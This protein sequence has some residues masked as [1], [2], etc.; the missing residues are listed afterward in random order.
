MS[1]PPIDEADQLEREVMRSEVEGLELLA[2]RL[3][4]QDRAATTERESL[5]PAWHAQLEARAA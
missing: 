4:R 5:E 2:R 3:A 1:Y